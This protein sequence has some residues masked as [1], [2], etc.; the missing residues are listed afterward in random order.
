MTFLHS[1]SKSP[2]NHLG[3]LS[4]HGRWTTRRS[5]TRPRPCATPVEMPLARSVFSCKPRAG[6]LKSPSRLISP[7][8]DV[9][10]LSPD[11]TSSSSCST[12]ACGFSQ[13][14]CDLTSLNPLPRPQVRIAAGSPNPLS[15]FTPESF[16]L[17]V[18]PPE[19]HLRPAAHRL[20]IQK[21]TAHSGESHLF[22]RSARSI[23][24]SRTLNILADFCQ[25][26]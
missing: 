3:S 18:Q 4:V 20:A 21:R 26:V 12:E 8:G 11:S 6:C 2:S 7:A 10:H 5:A 19:R 16:A 24:P 13:P 15:G 22:S 17:P 9:A 23:R 25:S 14:S 1:L